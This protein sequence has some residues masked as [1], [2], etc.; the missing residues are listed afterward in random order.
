MAI[1]LPRQQVLWRS[2]QK[3]VRAGALAA[4]SV[5]ALSPIALAQTVTYSEAFEDGVAYSAGDTQVDEWDAFRSAL[6]DVYSSIEVESSIGSPV[7][8]NDPGAVAQITN[9]LNTD[10]DISVSCDGN[11]W[12]VDTCFA[13]TELSI[14]VTP[15]SC[16]TT[17]AFTLRPGS[18]ATAGGAGGIWGGAG[19][20]CAGGDQTLSVV[21]TPFTGPLPIDLSLAIAPATSTPTTGLNTFID[22]IIDNGGETTGYC[23]GLASGQLCACGRSGSCH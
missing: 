8:C 22:I 23:R 7:T 3:T 11:V 19:S 15:C 20:T 2:L 10:A 16:S 5:F 13:A 18:G 9:A 17:S 21:A 14:G 4:L 6:T 12:E 1:R